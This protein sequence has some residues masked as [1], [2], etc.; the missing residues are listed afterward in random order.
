MIYGL[1]TLLASAEGNRAARSKVATFD[2]RGL[3]EEL[4]SD[5]IPS[6]ILWF[7]ARLQR[8]DY[9]P[10]LLEKSESY[11]Q[12]QSHFM[13]HIQA[14]KIQFIKIGYLRAREIDPCANCAHQGWKL[15]EK[16][17]DVGLAVR[18]VAEANENTEIVIISADTDLLPA[19][20]QAKKRGARLIHIGYE[21]RPIAA[22]SR[23]ADI[24]RII[25]LPL[26]EK[27]NNTGER[28]S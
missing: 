5:N 25:T 17:V 27:Y 14:Q 13:N 4:L 3:I 11:I 22:L 12:W 24:T 10:E 7:G 19:F 23:A 26:A 2:F 18:A 16:G 1:R 8:Y 6:Q 9:T 20:Q 28:T 15:A 21:Y